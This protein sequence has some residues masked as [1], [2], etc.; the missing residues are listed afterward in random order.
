M[1][2]SLSA[3]DQS[4]ANSIVVRP[5]SP[6]DAR[7]IEALIVEMQ[8]FERAIDPRLLPGREMAAE[9]RVDMELRCRTHAGAIFVAE[10][11]EAVVGFVAVQARVPTIELDQPPGHYA[12]IS[13]LSVAALH[14]SQ[15][16]G[17]QLLLA[18][19]AFAEESCADELR[20]AVLAGNDPAIHLY[21]SVGFEPYLH[22]LAKPL[23]K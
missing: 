2:G 3:V 8:E 23:S 5:Y 6:A 20:I 1:D 12:L 9:Y 19:E 22:L 16:I 7:A 13:D 17:R 14:R 10:A 21:G 11:S 4:V 18:A 15:G